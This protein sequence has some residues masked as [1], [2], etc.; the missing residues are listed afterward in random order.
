MAL[1]LQ[2]D[3]S[4]LFSLLSSIHSS[5][6]LQIQHVFSLNRTTQFTNNHELYELYYLRNIIP[7]YMNGMDY[8]TYCFYANDDSRFQSLTVFPCMIL[9]SEFAVTCSA[10]YQMGIFFH[11][12]AILQALWKLFF[13]LRDQCLP[14]FQTIPI[15]TDSVHNVFQFL[16][17]SQSDDEYLIGIQPEACLTPFLDEDIL[18]NNF[19]HNLPH[20]ADILSAAQNLFTRYAKNIADGKFIIYFTEYG[21]IQFQKYGTFAEIP[22]NF[23][24]PLTIPQ[25]IHVLHEVLECCHRGIYRILKKPLNNL[26]Q[27][28][29]LCIRGRDGFLNYQTN[30]GETICM[31]IYEPSMLQLFQDFLEHMDEDIYCTVDEAKKILT[32]LIQQLEVSVR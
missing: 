31:A 24:Q 26:A 13:S 10:D 18:Q 2:P 8:H 14:L 16:N 23:Y 21:L 30:S 28:L 9:T 5:E 22:K 4:F 32:E 15:A 29:H 6:S 25:R 19:N 27:N 11:D 3:Y 17:N 1:F 12:S 7:V 20:A